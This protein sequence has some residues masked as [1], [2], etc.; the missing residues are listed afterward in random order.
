MGSTVVEAMVGWMG[1][2]VSG[3]VV[4]VNVFL[5]GKDGGSCVDAV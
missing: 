2:R 5:V 1:E 3:L 4:G